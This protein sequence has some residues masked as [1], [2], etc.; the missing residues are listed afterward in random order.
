MMTKQEFDLLFPSG[1]CLVRASN[2]EEWLAVH[3]W[4][5]K[6][7]DLNPSGSRNS[8]DY[9]EYPYVFVQSGSYTLDAT[10]SLSRGQS[11]R[12]RNGKRSLRK[13]MK[14]LS[15]VLRISPIFCER[16]PRS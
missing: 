9:V 10:Y 7:Y 12:L 8:H 4:A 11:F 1:K 6:E 13:Q 16:N 2:T 3:D 5:V 15:S 14:M